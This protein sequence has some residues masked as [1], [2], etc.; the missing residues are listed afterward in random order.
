MQIIILGAHRSGTSMVTRL[1]NMMGAYFGLGEV[2]IGANSEN[3]KGFWE[4]ADVIAANDA[5]LKHYGCGWNKL[6][7]W[8]FFDQIA[9]GDAG[10]LADTTTSM[11]GIITELDESRPWVMK[12][13]RLCLT[14]PFWKPLL[15]NP[16]IVCVY[17]NPQEIAYSLKT[18][19]NIAFAHSMALWEYYATGITN[20]LRGSA[21]AYVSH[22]ALLADPVGTTQRLC[23]DLQTLGVTGLN[24]P[25]EA[26]I[27]AFVDPS[28]YRSR[29]D[30][31]A[32]SDMVTDYQKRLMAYVSGQET[33]PETLQHPTE[34]A[35]DL[36]AAL[37][38]NIDVQEKLEE[39]NHRYSQVIQ[40]KN[41]LENR[42][43]SIRREHDAVR[44]QYERMVE[45]EQANIR[46][47][48][49]STSWRLGNGIVK[50]L[51]TLT[52]Q[53]AKS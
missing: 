39:H 16:V 9:N 51:R 41:E 22:D 2:S 48:R 18:R 49:E 50:C 17:R 45:R 3:P 46:Y 53:G 38:E 1:V 14:Y 21:V 6:E 26:E 29:G 7:D 31:G 15:E 25:S 27:T 32:I 10:A 13:P 12:D 36:A 30:V 52:F 4:R 23:E 20:A 8:R 40:E 28:L 5:I 11:Q 43:E 42:L 35:K 37:N 19:N 47:L 44:E 33:V 34:L 24:A